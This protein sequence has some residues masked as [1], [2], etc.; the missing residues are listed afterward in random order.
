VDGAK[1]AVPL[2]GQKDPRRIEIMMENMTMSGMKNKRKGI[3]VRWLFIIFSLFIGCKEEKQICNKGIDLVPFPQNCSGVKDGNVS[4][5]WEFTP[6][7]EKPFFPSSSSLSV[8]DVDGDGKTEVV[9]ELSERYYVLNGE[10]GSILWS[11]QTKEGMDLFGVKLLGCI[12]SLIDDLNC[13][14]GNEIVVWCGDWNTYALNGKDGSVLWVSKKPF[15]HTSMG[16]INGDGRDEGVG[17]CIKMKEVD[18]NEEVE[19]IRICA[20]DW[21]NRSLLWKSKPIPS[22]VFDTISVGDLNSDGVPDVVFG[23]GYLEKACGIMALDGKNGSLLWSY[24]SP[25]KDIDSVMAPPVLGD[26]DEDGK[27]E[28]IAVASGEWLHAFNGEDGFL[29]LRRNFPASIALANTKDGFRIVGSGGV[30]MNVRGEVIFNK[31]E[32]GMLG[33]YFPVIGDVDGDGKLDTIVYKQ[34]TEYIGNTPYSQLL[35][36]AVSI[37][38]GSEHL[39]YEGEKK[40]EVEEVMVL[41]LA[42]VN[43][44]CILDLLVGIEEWQGKYSRVITLSL[45]VPVPP[46]HL[47][48]WPMARHD[49][50]GTS[51]YTG[52]PYPPW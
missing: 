25:E 48:P 7:S 51:L 24:L 10:D 30:V 4:I 5:L 31:R 15:S 32:N 9:V 52:D 13:D 40:R 26:I 3:K 42:D 6:S 22:S 43:N 14:G 16:D 36:Y 47:L 11:F 27:L 39:I 50:K 41:L 17:I 12:S 23:C 37:E 8:G 19:E 2:M 20:I 38:D 46:P 18:E 21:V 35:I 28:V 45:G 34:E 49:V 1:R 29:F 44:D 33:P